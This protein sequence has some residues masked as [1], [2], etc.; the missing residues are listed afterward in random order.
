MDPITDIF[1]T[2]QIRA[3][4]H[5]RLE[6]TAPWGLKHACAEAKVN[7]KGLPVPPS[8][9]AFFG[10]VARGNCWLNVD[11]IPEAIPLTG[12][13][14]F[15]LSPD[16]TYAFRDDPRTPTK[17]F[18]ELVMSKDENVIRYGGGGTPTSII[19]GWLYFDKPTLKPIAQLLPKLILI[20]AEQARSRALQTTLELLSSEMTE[21]APGS[22][23]VANRLAE[24][25]FI[26]TI[27]AHIGSDMKQ[28]NPGWLRAIFDP[29]VGAALRAIH[30]NVPHAWTVESLAESAGMSRSAFAARFKE[31]LG[32]APLEYLTEWRM[33]KAVLLL[34]QP[35]KKLFEIAKSVGY[36]SDAAFSKAFKRIVG[37]TPGEHRRNVSP[38][39]EPAAA[40]SGAS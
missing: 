29:Q 38:S 1:R 32:Q 4:V 5:A 24:V 10:M 12:G 39:I 37:I 23:V 36:E 3:I 19:S 33:Q 14:C 22:E 34:K 17:S 30:E 27:R 7:A 6:A 18:C 40:Y 31:L 11:G 35:D 26:Q 16:N 9:L 21:Q 2:M 28:C 20:K 8:E 25:L 15:L 13:D